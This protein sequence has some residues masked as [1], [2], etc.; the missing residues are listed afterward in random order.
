MTN[1]RVYRLE[2]PDGLG[3]FG[4]KA[5]VDILIPSRPL[6]QNDGLIHDETYYYGCRSKKQLKEYFS[7]SAIKSMSSYN[8][9]CSL[10]SVNKKYVKYSDQQVVF[11]RS[12]AKLVKQIDLQC[13]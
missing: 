11:K 8:I 2:T 9:V 7:P 6:G 3:V 12:V 1:R 13:F 10:Y 4:T 5:V